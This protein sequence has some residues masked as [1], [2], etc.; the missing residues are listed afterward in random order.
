MIINHKPHA[1][2]QS[3]FKNYST[4]SIFEDDTWV[5]DKLKKK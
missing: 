3:K 5:L 4:S 2:T 1:G